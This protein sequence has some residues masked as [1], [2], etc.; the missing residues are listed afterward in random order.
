MR[1]HFLPFAFALAG[2]ASLVASCG[3]APEV[4]QQ[5]GDLCRAGDLVVC[6]SLCERQTEV[7]ACFPIAMSYIN[8]E[9]REQNTERGERLLERGCELEHEQTCLEFGKRLTEREPERNSE[10]EHANR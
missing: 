2:L 5:P 6:E 9:G 3:G 1:T 7:D 8:G 10:A 4:P